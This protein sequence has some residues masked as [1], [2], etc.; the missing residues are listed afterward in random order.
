MPYDVMEMHRQSRSQVQEESVNDQTL[1][2]TMEEYF[3]MLKL[4]KILPLPEWYNDL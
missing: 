2:Q 1:E 4:C 3:S